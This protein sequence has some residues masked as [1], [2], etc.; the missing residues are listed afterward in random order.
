MHRDCLFYTHSNEAYGH[1]VLPF[2]YFALM[3]SPDYWVEVWARDAEK[4]EAH[5][6]RLNEMFGNRAELRNLTSVNP[7][8]SRF[9]E[10]P[11]TRRTWT[12]ISDI[13]ILTL[14]PHLVEW[15]A[16][17]LDGRCYSNAIREPKAWER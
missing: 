5:V 1:F 15:H 4:H 10:Q 7:A 12:Y 14:D 9:R 16:G 3:A 2:M 11:I 13:D 17:N 6:R 8:I